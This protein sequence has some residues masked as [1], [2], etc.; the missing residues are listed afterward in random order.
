[1]GTLLEFLG[2]THR[3]Y[4]DVC[5]YYGRAALMGEHAPSLELCWLNVCYYVLFDS[6]LFWHRLGAGSFFSGRLVVVAACI[7]VSYNSL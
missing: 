4:C 6:T 2:L 3:D 7:T 5:N 1:M